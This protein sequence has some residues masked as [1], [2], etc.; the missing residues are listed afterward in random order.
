MRG[1]TMRLA[2]D[3]LFHSAA[4]SSLDEIGALLTAYLTDPPFEISPPAE[5]SIAVSLAPAG[6]APSRSAWIRR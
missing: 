3:A 5:V 4:S 6:Q 2:F 1:D